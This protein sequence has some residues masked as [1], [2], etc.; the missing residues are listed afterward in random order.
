MKIRVIDVKESWKIEI[1]SEKGG[2]V[3]TPRSFKGK[4]K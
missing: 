2:N 1:E 3:V 4:R